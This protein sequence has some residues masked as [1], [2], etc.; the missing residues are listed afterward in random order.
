MCHTSVCELIQIDHY[1]CFW[2]ILGGTRDEANFLVFWLLKALISGCLGIRSL[3]NCIMS[4]NITVQEPGQ[5][6]RTGTEKSNHTGASRDPKQAASGFHPHSPPP[7]TF[8]YAV[9][10]SVL[11]FSPKNLYF[12]HSLFY[13][14]FITTHFS[15]FSLKLCSW[16]SWTL[17]NAALITS[18]WI[19]DVHLCLAG[20]SFG[21]RL[22]PSCTAPWAAWLMAHSNYWARESRANFVFFTPLCF[23]HTHATRN[24]QHTKHNTACMFISHVSP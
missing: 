5:E 22:Y 2:G 12:F 19:S 4:V 16:Q 8:R 17:L 15:I 7:E 14:H 10:S 21:R 1:C 11:S 23:Q 6:V 13:V 20:E 24:T 3:F 9:C 18:L